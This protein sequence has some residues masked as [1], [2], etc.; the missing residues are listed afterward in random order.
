MVSISQKPDCLLSHAQHTR[1]GIV[2]F[3]RGTS[4]LDLVFLLLILEQP[5]HHEP[6]YLGEFLF[7]SP[8]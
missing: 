6:A 4:A 5:F 8:S 2:P 3:F 7:Y 1:T